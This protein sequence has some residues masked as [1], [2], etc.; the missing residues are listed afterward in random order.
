MSCALGCIINN[1]SFKLVFCNIPHLQEV[2]VQNLLFFRYWH[3]TNCLEKYFWMLL[4][5]DS[6]CKTRR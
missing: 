5:H 4:P 3:E 2:T 1:V 6:T